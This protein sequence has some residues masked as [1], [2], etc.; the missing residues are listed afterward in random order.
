MV[1]ILKNI[2]QYW[3]LFYVFSGVCVCVYQLN[4]YFL[5]GLFIKKL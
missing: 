1:H 5:V 2:F 4:S 3:G